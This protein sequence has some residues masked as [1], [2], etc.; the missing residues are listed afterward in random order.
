MILKPLSETITMH[1]K[2]QP[3]KKILEDKDSH[4]SYIDV[5]HSHA[6]RHHVADPQHCVSRQALEE[7]VTLTVKIYTLKKKTHI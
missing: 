7:S 6:G 5:T 3:L 4:R 1:Y 2:L